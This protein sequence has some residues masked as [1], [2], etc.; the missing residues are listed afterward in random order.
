MK[1]LKI[2]LILLLAFFF[3]S[4]TKTPS[5][6]PSDKEP[7]SNIGVIYFSA[8]SNTKKL[9]TYIS[10]YYNA[11]LIEIVPSIP[12]TS[13]DL[14]YR[15]S[16]SRVSIEHSDNT[17]RPKI[18]NEIDISN[19]DYIFLGYPTWWG[20]APNILYTFV[21]NANFE[22]KTIIPFT[23]SASSPLGSSAKNLSLKANGK[24]N[25]G[26]RFSSSVKV[27]EVNAWL[28]ELNIK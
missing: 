21:E 15:N 11:S 25:E 13:S 9:A 8:T 28:K 1:N 24:W 5:N 17:I 26:I 18:K 3:T 14:D 27:T 16:S 12:Y 23:T 4:C 22:N 6:T 20:E 2:L 19:Y 10:N 7:S